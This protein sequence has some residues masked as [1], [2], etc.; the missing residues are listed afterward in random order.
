[1]PKHRGNDW[2]CNLCGRN[3]KV[4]YVRANKQQCP[5]CNC[6]K[7]RN[8]KLFSDRDKGKDADKTQGRDKDAA[9]LARLEKE[10]S[11][12]K[13]QL[14]EIKAKLA[15]PSVAAWAPADDNVYADDFTEKIKA[16]EKALSRIIALQKELPDVPL[17]LQ[18]DALIAEMDTLRKQQRSAKTPLQQLNAGKSK[19]AALAKKASKI[20]ADLATAVEEENVAREKAEKL[21][22]DYARV[23]A[24]TLTINA[25]VAELERSIST[26]STEQGGAL[27]LE[28]LL[29]TMRAAVETDA[30]HP[31]APPEAA[32]LKQE[33]D[34][35]MAGITPQLQAMQNFSQQLK[36]A[37][38]QATP[39]PA[40]PD[41]G[42]A[43]AGS[44]ASGATQSD[45]KAATATTAS[46]ST[47]ATASA[48][49]KTERSLEQLLGRP[50][51]IAKKYMDGLDVG[52][53]GPC[54]PHGCPHW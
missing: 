8:P 27:A 3:G 18:R 28:T 34:A 41:V 26:G 21:R 37:L 44:G 50:S 10:L 7:P 51:K 20:V 6:T 33:F 42:A 15:T 25:E 39:P 17:D 9:R 49:G 47:M 32:K 23:E 24:D 19:Q 36:A 54:L 46:D 1:M 38:L 2:L 40:A 4:F 53:C 35:A 52:R 43:G 30:T 14:K 31:K 13:K 22:G 16:K 29:E 5:E 12:A 11:N 48:A 45:E